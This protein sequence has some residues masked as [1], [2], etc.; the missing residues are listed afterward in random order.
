M[1]TSGPSVLL[2]ED[3]ASDARATIRAIRRVRPQLP[4]TWVSGVPEARTYLA[5]NRQQGGVAPGCLVLDLN[6]PGASGLEFLR[7]VRTHAE[8]ANLPVLILTTSQQRA[9]REAAALF[10]ANGYATKS[11]GLEGLAETGSIIARF[12]DRHVQGDI[13]FEQNTT[14]PDPPAVND[15]TVLVIEDD[16]GFARTLR[17]L[18]N[19]VLPNY[20][21]VRAS[22]LAE[23][24]GLLAD[25]KPA[26]ILTDLGLPD[27]SAQDTVNRL[28]EKAPTTPVVVLTGRS[29]DELGP[30][31]VD[32]GAQ[33]FVTKDSVD[34]A[35][36]ARVL[37]IAIRR[38]AVHYRE[39]H[40]AHHDSLTGLANRSH[41]HTSLQGRAER[42]RR[43]EQFGLL[44][45]DVNDFKDVND[46]Y[47]HRA[48]DSVL[49]AVAARIQD[50]VRCDDVAARWG[51]DEFA[52]LL[53]TV[54]SKFDAEST[55]TRIAQAING[56]V[57]LALE[58]TGEHVEYDLSVCIGVALSGVGQGARDDDELLTAADAAMYRAKS[59]DSPFVFADTPNR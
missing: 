16:D 25:T 14:A 5:E 46:R 18:L 11:F 39:V 59:V 45:I 9:D 10:G 43:G 1:T 28:V 13:I 58:P 27:S 3:N 35:E 24:L 6:L 29:F 21:H 37:R 15:Q 12:W 53:G 50:V 57:T 2:L 34:A 55:A 36:L 8:T 41:F 32:A 56:P 47:G 48:G 20:E 49:K 40:A 26:V 33:D 38:N 42:A 23:G 51:G 31:A 52:V 7:E 54:V 22:N 4:V 19:Q 44:F 17:R 30:S